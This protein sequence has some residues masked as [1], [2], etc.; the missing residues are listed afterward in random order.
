MES[1]SS[2]TGSEN[3]LLVFSAYWPRL[4]KDENEGLLGYERRT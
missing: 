3:L 1:S 4:K 2:M